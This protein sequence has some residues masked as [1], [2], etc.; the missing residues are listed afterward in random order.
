MSCGCCGNDKPLFNA[1]EPKTIC[2]CN[3]IT[4]HEIIKTV[5]E[6]GLTSIADVK[7]YLRGEVVSNCAELNP[8][9]MCCHQSFDAVIQ[10]AMKSYFLFHPSI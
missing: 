9:G 3:K 5:K 7:G 2:Y 8:M 4:D 10:Y 1:G 6:T